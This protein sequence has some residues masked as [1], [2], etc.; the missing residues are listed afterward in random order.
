MVHF[1]TMSCEAASHG[2]FLLSTSKFDKLKSA[3][4]FEIGFIPHWVEWQWPY[5]LSVNKD[6]YIINF[7]I[8]TK[9]NLGSKLIHNT[10]FFN[11]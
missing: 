9:V 1:G 10:V 6:K 2:W 5:V 4:D 11:S 8:K 3:S 7:K